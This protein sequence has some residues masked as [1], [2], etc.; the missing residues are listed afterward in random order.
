MWAPRTENNTFRC[1]LKSEK[2][3]ENRARRGRRE[4]LFF[5]FFAR[6]EGTSDHFQFGGSF[7]KVDAAAGE[8]FEDYL[9]KQ[10]HWPLRVGNRW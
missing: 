10:P 4:G 3:L 5:F 7:G 8:L 1:K 6:A 2:R 9:S